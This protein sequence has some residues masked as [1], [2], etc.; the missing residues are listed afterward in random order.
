MT[1]YIM[2]TVIKQ[3]IRIRKNTI[4]LD[5]RDNRDSKDTRD[6]GLVNEDN[7]IKMMKWILK[8]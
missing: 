3:M 8:R 4:K 5:N 6:K 2:I 1:E 7:R